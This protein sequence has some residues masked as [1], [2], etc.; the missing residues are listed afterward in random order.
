[1]IDSA[2]SIG[3]ATD[4]SGATVLGR[5]TRARQSGA[6]LQ[7]QS[8][9]DVSHR[10]EPVGDYQRRTADV[11][12]QYH[13][14][15]ARRH[16]VVAGAGYRLMHERFAGRMGYSLTPEQSTDKLFNVFAQDEIAMAGNRIHATLGAKVER[17]DLAGWGLQPT[18]R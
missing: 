6:S 2:A 14:A 13:T 4:M 17:D 11:D 9:V 10:D 1:T 12:V 18:A 15:I 5:W 3:T 8:F 16:D 7:V